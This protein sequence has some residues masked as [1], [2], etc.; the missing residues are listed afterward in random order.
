M[1]PDSC[2][3]IGIALREQSHNVKDNDVKVCSPV[4]FKLSVEKIESYRFYINL[5]N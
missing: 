3:I 5:I 1:K 2:S 4:R